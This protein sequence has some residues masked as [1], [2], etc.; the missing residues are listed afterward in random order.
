MGDDDTKIKQALR[1]ATEMNDWD[2][3]TI[4]DPLAIPV[5]DTAFRLTRRTSSYSVR[6]SPAARAVARAKGRRR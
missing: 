5:T 3:S 2:F 4:P 1:E 6:P